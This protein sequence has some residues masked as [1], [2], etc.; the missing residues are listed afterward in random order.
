MLGCC[1]YM[2]VH[3][4][5]S[6]ISWIGARDTPCLL[7]RH[8]HRGFEAAPMARILG[9]A[10][11]G[12]GSDLHC[13]TASA[14]APRRTDSSFRE[15]QRVTDPNGRT[16]EHGQS[17]TIRDW[18]H[19][20]YQRIL[21]R[22]ESFTTHHSHDQSLGEVRNSDAIP[23]EET[24]TYATPFSHGDRSTASQLAS[25]LYGDTRNAQRGDLSFPSSE[26]FRAVSRSPRRGG[27]FGQR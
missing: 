15:W 19:Q 12:V 6:S 18:Q 17:W 1:L 4:A 3:G 9:L 7:L 23:V 20:G 22:M 11:S 14:M 21:S 13:R 25:V 2:V 8:G 5:C 10:G 24:F 16:G 26:R 27:F